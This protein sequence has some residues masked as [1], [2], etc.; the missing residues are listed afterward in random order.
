[1][2]LAIEVSLSRWLA[3]HNGEELATRHQCEDLE[4]LRH[5]SGNSRWESFWAT[6]RPASW[7]LAKRAIED[8]TRIATYLS[9]VGTNYEPH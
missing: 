5:G 7:G 3:A 4:Y 9:P 6:A 2:S 1:M 8:D